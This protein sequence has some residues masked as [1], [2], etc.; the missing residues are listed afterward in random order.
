[1]HASIIDMT[2]RLPSIACCSTSSA[3]TFCHRSCPVADLDS[4]YPVAPEAPDLDLQT[5]N[6]QVHRRGTRQ[7]R[8]QPNSR[9]SK[10]HWRK[11]D[12]H[13][14]KPAPHRRWGRH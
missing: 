8:G 3:R 14:E 6:H 13:T 4:S 10:L 1:M 11:P 12:R 9:L 5:S 2:L 7:P